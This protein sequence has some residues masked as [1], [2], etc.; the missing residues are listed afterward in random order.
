MKITEITSLQNPQIKHL[1]SLEKSKYRKQEGKFVIEGIRMMEEALDADI[2]LDA[3][4]Y[5]PALLDTTRGKDLFERLSERM[6]KIYLLS[7]RL[8]KQVGFTET[9]QGI[10]AVAS[11]L[12]FSLDILLKNANPFFLLLDQIQD[13][14][15]L[16]TLIRT[17]DAAGVSGVILTEGTVDLYNP[18]TIRATMGSLFHLPILAQ[19]DGQDIIASLQREGIQVLAAALQTD[20]YFYEADF[21]R[22]TAVVIGNEGQGLSEEVLKAVDLKIKI[23]ILGKAES[24][25]AAVAGAI[26]VYEGARHRMK[27]R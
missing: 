20:T 22:P 6:L 7:D 2:G 27:S 1:R 26:L 23:P 11:Q 17:A 25:N 21:T 3:I 5:S 9:P 12:H 13:P 14:G 24:L 4:Y 19:Q 18:K 10:I 16:G 8:M 15:N